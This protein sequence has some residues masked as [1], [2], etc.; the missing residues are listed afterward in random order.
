M[1]R[2]RKAL[3]VAAVSV[4]AGVFTTS[5][6]RAEQDFSQY[7][8]EELVRLRN[9]VRNLNEADRLRF[10]QE[11]QLRVRNMDANERARLGLETDS[12]QQQLRERVN[13]HNSRG[14]GEMNRERDR[15]E[16]E[17]GYGRGFGTRSGGMGGSHTGGR[18][19]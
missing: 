6:V 19:R 1:K 12:R 11:L 16:N 10:Q 5:V 17:K 4:A 9:Q 18:G 2:M 13:E 14:Q 15:I 8:N 3:V 7:S